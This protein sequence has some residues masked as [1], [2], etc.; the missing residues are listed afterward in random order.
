MNLG[1]TLMLR[2]LIRWLFWGALAAVGWERYRM[3]RRRRPDDP[4]HEIVDV[5]HREE[6]IDLASRDSFPCSD[7]P[8]WTATTSLGAPAHA[9]R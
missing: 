4:P 6:H 2:N 8:S 1:V 3:R 7:A 5:Q 9:P